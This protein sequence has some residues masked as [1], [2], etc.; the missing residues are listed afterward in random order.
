MRLIGLMDEKDV[1]FSKLEI[2]ICPKKDEI[3]VSI[4]FCNPT[5]DDTEI[6]IITI[7]II[8]EKTDIFIIGEETVFLYV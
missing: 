2:E 4:V 6:I 1:L 5:L 8:I 3:L 7:P